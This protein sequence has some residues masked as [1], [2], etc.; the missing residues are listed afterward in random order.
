VLLLSSGVRCGTGVAW[1]CHLSSNPRSPPPSP[2]LCFARSPGLTMAL[3]ISVH[4]LAF[5]F[6]GWVREN[7]ESQ[8]QA[9]HELWLNDQKRYIK[10]SRVRKAVA[11]ELEQLTGAVPSVNYDPVQGFRVA[12]DAVCGIQRRMK[13]VQLVFGLFQAATPATP[14]FTLPE[15]DTEEDPNVRQRHSDATSHCMHA[16]AVACVVSRVKGEEGLL[17][18]LGRGRG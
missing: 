5:D 7:T 18:L 11:K 1:G 10:E 2:L 9:A 4:V 16:P 12:F 17:K 3:L 8:A 6:G 13:R 15:C 14:V